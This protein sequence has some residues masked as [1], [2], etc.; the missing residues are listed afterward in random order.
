MEMI[1]TMRI[2]QVRRAALLALTLITLAGCQADD[3]YGDAPQEEEATVREPEPQAQV[4]SP[5][6][7]DQKKRIVFFGNSLTAGYGL[8]P[9]QAFPA[10][11]QQKIDSLG[12]PYEV[13]NAGNS[14]ET[15]AGGLRRVDWILQNP[16]D[17]F[18]LELGPNDGLRGLPIAEMRRNLQGILDKVREKYPQARL[19][20]SGMQIPANMGGTYGEQFTA[21]YPALAEANDA[22]LIPFLLRDVGGIAAL[23]LSDGIHPNARGH[24]IMAETVWEVLQPVLIDEM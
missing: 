2:N 16:V 3:N 5:Q 4:L 6:R 23:N 13:V 12:L 14:G 24:R 7:T 9:Q 8:D 17:V 11:I 21:V 19:V 15:T 22:T 1:K 18:V 10:L 20:V